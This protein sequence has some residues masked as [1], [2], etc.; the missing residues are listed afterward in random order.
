MK[1]TKNLFYYQSN[2]LPVL[3]YKEVMIVLRASQ[4][5]LC[6]AKTRIMAFMGQPMVHPMYRDRHE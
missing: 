4:L 6:S 1:L 5:G 3:K 2:Q